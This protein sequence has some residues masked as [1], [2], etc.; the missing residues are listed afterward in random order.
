MRGR[1]GSVERVDSAAAARVRR[2][3]PAQP[4]SGSAHS[5]VTAEHADAS[6]KQARGQRVGGDARL[7]Q[8]SSAICWRRQQS[9]AARRRTLSGAG[10]GEEGDARH[11]DER[12][13][14]HGE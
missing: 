7:A 3:Q 1:S 6:K 13:A 2:M 8:Q 11:G 12:G 4:P 10:A 5:S 14:G 9:G